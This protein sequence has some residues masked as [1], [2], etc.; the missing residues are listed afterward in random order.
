[1]SRAAA[2]VIGKN[3]GERLIR[4]LRSLDGEAAPVIYVDSGSEDGSVE[5]ARDL[6]ATVVELDMSRPFTAARARNAGIAVLP[7]DAPDFVQLVDGDC[8][9]EP[10]WIEAAAV[11]LDAHPQA[12][13]VAGRLREREAEAS[14]W[15]RLADAEWNVPP[16]PGRA[17]GGIA[18]VRRSALAEV[19]GFRDE[20]A[21]GEEPDLS[22]RLLAKGREVWRIEGEMGRHDIGMTHLSQWWRRARR[23]GRAAA[24]LFALHKSD[25][26]NPF[27]AEIRRML[28]W[29]A[30]PPIA[31]ILG[32][33]LLGPAALLLLLAW[34]LQIIRLRIRG[35]TWERAF[36]LTIGKIAEADGVLRYWLS[37]N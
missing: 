26:G 3:E 25:A 15:S 19:G 4:C 13:A 34:P 12:A 29:G 5:V 20:L 36:F 23:G 6:G 8:E 27:T 16:G 9:M 30:V 1:M 2:V 17:I 11:F 14:V 18:M 37:R 28:F 32:A 7:D 33:F 24:E 21:Q 35:E 22:L 10:G 31:T